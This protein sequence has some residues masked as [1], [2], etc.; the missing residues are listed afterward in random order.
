MDEIGNGSKPTGQQGQ[1]MA[2]KAAATMQGTLGGARV[3]AERGANEASAQVEAVRSQAGPVIEK[4]GGQ[5]QQLLQQGREALTDTTQKVRA[6]VG[7][8]SETALAYTKDEPLNALLAAAATGAVLMG[9]VMMLTRSR[10]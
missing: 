5:A 7:Q 3:T 2:N 1:D 6:K 10:D 4:L 8:A 9:M